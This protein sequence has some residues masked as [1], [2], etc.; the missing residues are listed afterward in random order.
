MKKTFSMIGFLFSTNV[1]S[2]ETFSQHQHI[3]PM[4]SNAVAE[5]P[6]VVMASQTPFNELMILAMVF[7]SIISFAVILR[8]KIPARA[9]ISK[10]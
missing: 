8:K 3:E 2:H 5:S 4:I 7:V 9:K 6:A 1:F 10:D